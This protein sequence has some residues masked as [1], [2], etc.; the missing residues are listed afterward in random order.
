MIH[1]AYTPA[2]V[3][4]QRLG[5]TWGSLDLEKLVE[6]GAVRDGDRLVYAHPDESRYN[7]AKR[8]PP[9]VYYD[10]K[11]LIPGH[12]GTVWAGARAVKTGGV[13]I[14]FHTKWDWINE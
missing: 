1:P 7:H 9:G 4:G 5:S 3:P 14:D 11:Q 8:F 2:R 12:S 13:R 10:P 6:D